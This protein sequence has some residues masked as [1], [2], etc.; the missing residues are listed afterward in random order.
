MLGV[1]GGYAFVASATAAPNSV[2]VRTRLRVLLSIFLLYL[3]RSPKTHQGILWYLIFSISYMSTLNVGFI[4]DVWIFS[5][6]VCKKISLWSVYLFYSVLMHFIKWVYLILFSSLPVF[7]L[8]KKHDC[9]CYEFKSNLLFKHD[10]SEIHSIINNFPDNFFIFTQDAGY[11]NVHVIAKVYFHIF[12]AS[13]QLIWSWIQCWPFM[14]IKFF[15][16]ID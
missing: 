10:I 6:W 7:E 11:V 13:N 9:C 12:D 3:F 16:D 4:R 15:R 1:S 14:K 2:W 8:T 5:S